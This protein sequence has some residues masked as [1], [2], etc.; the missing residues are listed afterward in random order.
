MKMIFVPLMWTF[1]FVYV[2]SRGLLL[3]SL[4]CCGST[5]RFLS[6]YYAVVGLYCWKYEKLLSIG[7][8]G[9]DR[10]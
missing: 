7:S 6:H 3:V 10:L 1:M 8:L 2:I 4:H 9:V 5:V